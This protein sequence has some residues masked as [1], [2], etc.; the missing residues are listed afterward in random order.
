MMDMAELLLAPR[1]PRADLLPTLA[2]VDDKAAG[3]PRGEIADALMDAMDRLA[4]PQRAPTMLELAQAAQVGRLAAERT[5]SNLVRRGAVKIARRRWVAYRRSPVA[6]YVRCT[7]ADQAAAQA[8]A[9]E[10]GAAAG[11]LTAAVQAMAR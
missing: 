7:P 10:Q 6:E 11:R 4:T 8:A 5:L 2:L 3:R 9:A 1:R